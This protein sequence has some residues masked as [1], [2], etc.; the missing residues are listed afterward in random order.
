M[1]YLLDTCTISDFVK[2]EVN[3]LNHFKKVQ[4][5]SLAISTITLMEINYGL[6]IN[7]QKAKKINPIIEEIFAKVAILNFTQKEAGIAS[8]IRSDLKSK[9]TPIG[10]YD[11]L[12]A[13]TAVNHQLIL[14][15]SNVREF[16]RISHLRVENWRY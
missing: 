1:R 8:S 3:T 6:L 13:A 11:V 16:N 14:V 12:I 10:Y 4:I 5:Q 7:P 2:G 9:G 15:T